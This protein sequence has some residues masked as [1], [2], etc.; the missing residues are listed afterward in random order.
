MPLASSA[1][2]TAA[3]NPGASEQPVNKP[4]RESASAEDKS[5]CKQLSWKKQS[6]SDG[7][8]M[9][10][11]MVEW[12]CLTW[13][14]QELLT[15]DKSMCM[16]STNTMS[17]NYEQYQMGLPGKKEYQ[18]FGI[19]IQRSQEMMNTKQMELEQKRRRKKLESWLKIPQKNAYI[20]A[21]NEPLFVADSDPPDTQPTQSNLLSNETQ[22]SGWDPTQ[23]SNIDLIFFDY[24]QLV[25]DKK[26]GDLNVQSHVAPSVSPEPYY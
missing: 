21:G 5:S 19:Q 12:C 14:D 2:A 10:A 1:A 20:V 18:E 11:L 8:T 13:G 25:L 7:K 9:L 26:L 24:T 17:T 16:D 23:P 3:A 22:Y 15:D 6:N 4:K